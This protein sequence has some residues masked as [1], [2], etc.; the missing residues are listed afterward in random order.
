VQDSHDKNRLARA[1]VTLCRHWLER[2]W[3]IEALEIVSYAANVLTKILP[4]KTKEKPAGAD[5]HNIVAQDRVILF[6]A[7][8]LSVQESDQ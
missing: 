2:A 8:E 5:R 6:A 3:Q 1:P 7:L 4:L